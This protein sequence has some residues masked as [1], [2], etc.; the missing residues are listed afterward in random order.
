MLNPKPGDTLLVPNV[1]SL[2]NM[3]LQ[4]FE[5]T[6]KKPIV[7]TWA[8]PKTKVGGYNAYGVSFQNVK[9]VILK[10]FFIDCTKPDGTRANGYALAFGNGCSDI[11]I[12]D[13][14][15]QNSGAGLTVK[16]QPTN[17]T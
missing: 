7:I 8:N 9:H 12:E 1:P 17:A 14:T 15:I 11:K 2:I 16:W 5:G 13:G 10:N 3:N 4:N 6:A